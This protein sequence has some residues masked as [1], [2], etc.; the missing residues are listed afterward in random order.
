MGIDYND[1]NL[2][3]SGWST[4][5]E[6]SFVAFGAKTEGLKA[7]KDQIFYP[8]GPMDTTHMISNVRLLSET[9]HEATMSA[10]ALAYHYRT[11]QGMK[12]DADKYVSGVQ[13][14]L[15]LIKEGEL[16]KVKEWTM[17]ITWVDGNPEVMKN[18]A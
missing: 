8:I 16:W 2:F 4:T 18:T 1:V 15:N 9:E 12:A 7:I 14:H 13:Y 11:G 3:D 10:Y 6:P 17:H 5:V